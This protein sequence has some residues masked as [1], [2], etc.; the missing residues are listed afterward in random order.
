LKVSKAT[1]QQQQ[2]F[3]PVPL[4]IIFTQR[5]STPTLTTAPPARSTTPRSL[6]ID[7]AS[8]DL[9]QKDFTFFRRRHH[10]RGCDKCVCNNCSSSKLIFT[11]LASPGTTAPLRA[12]DEC[13]TSRH[14]AAE[15]ER[16][17]KYLDSIQAAKEV[18]ERAKEVRERRQKAAD[19]EISK[20]RE[21][22][23]FKEWYHLEKEK[24]RAALKLRKQ[25]AEEERKKEAL[26]LRKQLAEASADSITATTA[27]TTAT[28]TTTTAR[29]IRTPTGIYYGMP[30]YDG[31]KK[32][33]KR[34]LDSHN[35]WY[36]EQMGGMEYFKGM[37][38]AAPAAPTDKKV[39]MLGLDGAGKTTLLYTLKLGDIITTTPTVG[40]NM[41]NIDRMNLW[42]IGG[43]VRMRLGWRHFYPNTDG[44]IFVVDSNCSRRLEEARAALHNVVNEKEL[45]NVAVLVIANKQDLPNALSTSA[46]TEQLDLHKLCSKHQ[47]FIQATSATAE[48]GL[49]EGMAW[50]S[51]A[52]SK[53]E[54][55]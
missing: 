34:M 21:Q 22:D 7:T 23:E 52:L 37:L 18:R 10:C 41:E 31:E 30:L 9:C 32:P 53:G 49:K 11:E 12:C 42:D 4:P 25:L 14:E 33:S 39:L 2:S 44:L 54:T 26:V 15:A 47:W 1:Q 51:N 38:A 8:C 46:M 50:L 40:F 48:N 16:L 28:T 3:I 19:E 17:Q 24:N 20:K 35:N 29:T 45:C 13:I 27:A 36:M 43:Q 6:W 55:T 5:M